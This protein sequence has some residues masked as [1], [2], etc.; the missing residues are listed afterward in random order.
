MPAAFVMTKGKGS[1]ERR[2]GES[3]ASKPIA[4]FKSIISI[5]PQKVKIKNTGSIIGQ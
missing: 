4:S 1:D 3:R 5:L 2:P